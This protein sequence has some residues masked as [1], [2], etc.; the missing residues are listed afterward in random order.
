MKKPKIFERTNKSGTTSYGVDSGNANGKRQRKYF[1]TRKAAEE[2]RD[3][4]HKDRLK[5]G[6]Q[7]FALDDRQR[8]ETVQA[9][10]LL[11]GTQTSL[12]DAVKYYVKH[13]KPMCGTIQTD[14]LIEKFIATKI[15][16]GKKPRYVKALR[17]AYGNFSQSFGQRSFNEISKEEI[18]EW[19]KKQPFQP[20]TKRN[21]LRD[22]GMLAKFGMEEG[23][24]AANVIKRIPKPSLIDKPVE[25]FTVAE[26]A[27]ILFA[28]LQFT[29]SLVPY[30]AIG[31]FAGLRSSELETLDWKEINLFAKTIEVQ[32]AKAKTSSRRVVHI[33]D[34][35][36]T[37]L[38][39][40]E[41]QEGQ[42]VTCGWRDRLQKLAKQAGFEKWPN[43]VLRHSFGS[44]HLA[45][46]QNA[47]LTALEMGH[48]TSNMLFKHYRAVVTK[49]AAGHYWNVIPPV[50]GLMFT[51]I[52][53]PPQKGVLTNETKEAIR[54]EVQEEIKK[55]RA[56][57]AI[58]T[59][60]TPKVTFSFERRRNLSKAPT[61]LKT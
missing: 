49:E 1:P 56:Q 39:P 9:L 25:I 31:L 27:R 45:H 52:V 58:S 23:H 10:V 19:F 59:K 46:H 6:E 34:N 17:S 4:I 21:Y 61:S 16:S 18:E 60:K 48:E 14:L 29:P 37:W 42:I 32:A 3:K 47:A 8:M 7:A 24:C 11:E 20:P 2:Y 30:L 35:L 57:G 15:E 5:F 12:L 55:A 13:A 50:K 33:S 28:G 41:K 51:P 53:P 54:Q 38:Q 22:L 44:Y 36:V 43:N 40:H 26:A